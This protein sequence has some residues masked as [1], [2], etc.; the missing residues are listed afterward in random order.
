MKKIIIDSNA[1]ISYLTNRNLKQQEIADRY[2]KKAISLE[3]ELIIPESVI[4]ETVYVFKS[5]YS[6]HDSEINKI[7]RSLLDVPGIKVSNHFNINQVIEI[8]PDKIKDFGD[9]IIFTYAGKS[10]IP[11]LTFDKKFQ[12]QLKRMGI[13]YINK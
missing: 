12:A 8:W 11:I 6:I 3:F 9:A 4:F 2:F 13:S 1:L 10:K 7:I 5:I